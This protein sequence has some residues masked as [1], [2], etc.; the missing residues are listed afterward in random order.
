MFKKSTPTLNYRSDEIERMVENNHGLN[1]RKGE[2]FMKKIC[3][4][5]VTVVLMCVA[6][7]GCS[8]LKQ[9]K[10]NAVVTLTTSTGQAYVGRSFNGAGMSMSGQEAALRYKSEVV[11]K[12]GETAVV[13][14]KCDACGNEQ[15]YK[16]DEAWAETISCDCPEKIDEN[17]NAKEY[18][19]I[20]ISFED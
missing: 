19:A 12:K 3:M 4:M 18:T 13:A 20:S 2:Y 9:D 11:L 10:T 5:M 16:V 14:F 6:L 7:T 17:G 8:S 1:N 15:E